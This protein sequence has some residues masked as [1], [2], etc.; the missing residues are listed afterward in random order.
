MGI[1]AA[2]S[3][4]IARDLD[5]QTPVIK[6]IDPGNRDSGLEC[7]DGVSFSIKNDVSPHTVR[8]C[9]PSIV[10]NPVEKG[11]LDLPRALPVTPK[12]INKPPSRIETVNEILLVLEGDDR[13]VALSIDAEFARFSHARFGQVLAFGID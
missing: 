11:P 7:S 1:G 6:R 10:K 13:N 2:R 3:G 5:Q 4:F 9:D 8:Q 12:G